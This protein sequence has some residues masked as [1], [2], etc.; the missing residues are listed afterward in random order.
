MSISVVSAGP[1]WGWAVAMGL[2]PP[3][4]IVLIIGETVILRC[5]MATPTT[6]RRCVA[7]VWTRW[8]QVRVS[9]PPVVVTTAATTSATIKPSP[10][11]TFVL[12]EEGRRAERQGVRASGCQGV[13]ASGH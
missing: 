9:P 11:V 8:P 7:G 6:A 10:S 1:V 2:A 12:G 5:A 13:R 4:N 3:L